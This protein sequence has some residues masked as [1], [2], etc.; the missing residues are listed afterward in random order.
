VKAGRWLAVAA[1]LG[2]VLVVVLLVRARMPIAERRS[3][4]VGEIQTVHAD[5]RVAS[6]VARGVTRFAAGDSIATGPDGRARIRLDDGTTV[7][8]DRAT[9]LGATEH[10]L[11]LGTGRI[12]VQGGS[13][14]RT[15]IAAGGTTTI[16]RGSTLAFERAGDG[17]RVYCASGEAVVRGGST[18][19][20]VQSGETAVL[21]GQKLEVVPEKAFND[22]T[23]GMATPWSATGRPRAAIGEL[24]GRLSSVPDEGGAP[25]AIRS[26][27]VEAR[28]EGEVAV[29]RVETT[30]F[31]GGSAAVSGD[32]RMA[33]PHGS[34]VSRFALHRA[35]G[36]EEGGVLTGAGQGAASLPRLEWAGP[37]WVRG[38]I[39]GIPAGET[40]GVIVEYVEWLSAPG[41]HMTY[42]YPMV[43]DGA[44]P[45]IGE[46]RARVDASA[47][48]AK[49]ITVGRG[50][51][52]VGAVVELR[53]ADVRPEADLVVELDVPEPARDR[54]R[55]YVA[56]PSSREPDADPYLLVRAEVPAG[57][58]PDGV[59]VALVL[60]TSWSI[61]PSSL[62]A[63]RAVAEAVV[64]GL[65]PRDRVVV[66]SADQHA[67]P[68]GPPGLAPLDDA[69][70]R[71]IRE[72]LAA[73]RPGGASDLGGALE[74]ARDA[75][76]ADA[77]DAMVVYVGDGWPTVGDPDMEAVRARL[78]RRAGGVPRLAAIA[79]GPGANRFGLASLVRGSGPVLGV[80]DRPDAAQAAIALLAG[81]LEPVATGV[82]LDLGATVDR[83]YPRGAQA[84]VGGGTVTVVGRLRGEAPLSVT[85]AYQRGSR[86][87]SEK[88][89]VERVAT[90]KNGDVR[91]RWAEA[92]VH[93]IVLRGESREI[94][95]D[96][97]QR[98]RLL[99]PWTS[100]VVAPAG[101]TTYLAT[102]FEARVLDASAACLA[103]PPSYLGLPPHRGG[104]ILEP[105][106]PRPEAADEDF[107]ELVSASV[108]RTL[109]AAMPKVRRCRDSRL[110]LRPEIGERLLVTLTVDGAGHATAVR[111]RG[112]TT[113]TDD[114]ALD[115]CVQATVESL[116]FF[117][118]GTEAQVTVER[119]LT[120]PPPR[121]SRARKCS[122]TSAL[123]L[124]LRVTVWRERLGTLTPWEAYARARRTC[125]LPGWA[126][127][128]G[129]L[130]LVL[131]RSPGGAARF[132]VA[133]RLEEQGDADAAAYVRREAVR[134]AETPGELAEVRRALVSDEPV[135]GRTFETQYGKAHDDD[136]RLVVVRRFLRLSPHDSRLRRLLLV[137]LERLGQKDALVQETH[138]VREDAFS[139]AALLS[140]AASALRRAGR[141]LE[142]RR[143]FGE[144]VERAPE[145][146]FA[147]AYAGDRLRDEGLFDDAT[148][149]YEALGI[150]LP[151]EPAAALRLALAHAGAGRLDVATRVLE[152]VAETGG[153]ADDTG[154]GELAS[155]TAAVL[156]EDARGRATG[157]DAARLARRALE[158]PLPDVAG[159]VLVRTPALDVPVEPRLVH[160]GDDR[161][162]SPPDLA[163]AS[164]GLFAMRLERGASG[165]GLVLRRPASLDAGWPARVRADVLTF[166]EGERQGKL[167][168]YDVT[169]PADGK[170]VLVFGE[171]GKQP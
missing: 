51:T 65:G 79:V 105:P 153:R 133:A 5:V 169:V 122:Q 97:A 149:A 48:R 127:Q 129:L 75:L 30:Y 62:D 17:V 171:G 88:R 24:W 45:M 34:I 50:A 114:P 77:P 20:H 160:G 12:F 137:L 145:D 3:A 46:L 15:E 81:A 131:D 108:R 33:L 73:L 10:G 170:D 111:V 59:T 155:M 9:E 120:L 55:A 84:V 100:W 124:P 130:D 52:L 142:G 37:D 80:T 35:S 95:S 123:P 76:P 53:Q 29:T 2:A 11:A 39:P 36:V 112:T 116:P 8:V 135:A 70:R 107:R 14:A 106:A 27:E 143:A 23:A 86:H 71:A 165:V 60:D 161:A 102:P 47:L 38:A 162:E 166:A 19:S 154:L 92:R 110:A 118:S 159:F 25:L 115:R 125:E 6:H 93:D 40:V 64:E 28:L 54:V 139:D 57:A 90:V 61:A 7:V 119:E 109:D 128:R 164:L 140:D 126:E 63:E 16:A 152:R 150:M 136:A 72:G 141:D 113:G 99:T 89:L 13:A 156:L 168:H 56:R 158:V 1:L 117:D 78:S 21:T 69:R 98:A 146:P 26:H 49:S 82:T 157:D 91:R 103:V 4:T 44:A 32:F 68:I 101:V 121:E 31:N 167:A 134:R 74:A 132:G 87:E 22:W 151:D 148:V 85:L 96:I 163:A 94:A 42:R 67:Q 104:A 138:R 58:A 43:S 144:L 83:V 147:R 18:Q 41:G 66:L